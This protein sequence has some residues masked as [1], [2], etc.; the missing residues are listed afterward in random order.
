MT[1][2]KILYLTLFPHIGGGETS[3]LYLL[4]KLD[5]NK[6]TPIV[7][8][9]K[10]GQVSERLKKMQIE[11]HIIDLPG[12]LIRTL[13]MPGM[14]PI[15]LIKLYKIVKKIK[16]NLI[17]L[18]HP[19]LAFYAGIVGKLL[20][21]P[22]VA[23]SHGVWDCLYFYQDIINRIFIDKLLPISPEVQNAL[24]KRHIIPKEKTQVIFLGIDT[25]RF[26]PGTNKPEA[27]KK[28]GI[29]KTNLVV[30]MA[31]RF[32]F[33]KNH[34]T[35][36]K[37]ANQILPAFP[38][39]KFLIVGDTKTNLEDNTNMTIQVK[40][41]LDNFISLH[42]HLSNHII[43]TDFQ[44]D[45]TQIYHATDI[46]FSS[47]LAETLP[48]SLIEGASCGLPLIALENLSTKH[49]II[50]E[51]NGFLIPPDKKN[52][53]SSYLLK[54]LKSSVLR[55]H[56]GKYSRKYVLKNLNVDRYTKNI[57]QIYNSFI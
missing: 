2:H 38:N 52:L 21:I 31:C 9:T 16:P 10:P 3:L 6:Y 4:E 56:Y 20:H 45:M 25:N 7:I 41:Q 54:L 13:F 34:L 55:N 36:L 49:I 5:K 17:H 53:L 35:F 11:T 40:K 33:G 51:K 8:V 1:K 37:V 14:S 46:I 27:K 28:F 32:D 29:K 48:M 24:I 18:N 44:E 47:S 23:T 50:H 26:A 43:F 22:V 39:V 15:G 42:P 30:T 12:F 57:T 19:F